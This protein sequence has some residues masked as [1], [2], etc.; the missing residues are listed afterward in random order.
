M[1][2]K[3]NTGNIVNDAII[4]DIATAVGSLDY[5]TVT[6]KVHEAKIVQIEVTEKKRFDDI[7]RLEGG[8]GI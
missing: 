6:I 2:L 4:K 8:G 5:G 3:L 1:S 7:W